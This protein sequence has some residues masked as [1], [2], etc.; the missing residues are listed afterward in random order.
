MLIAPSPSQ[1]LRVG[2][3]RL[4]RET[5]EGFP[6]FVGAEPK[7]SG[8]Y[9]STFTPFQKATRPVMFFAASFGSG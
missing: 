8:A 1:W 9:F 2:E 3:G 7:A 4:R 6:L 5:V